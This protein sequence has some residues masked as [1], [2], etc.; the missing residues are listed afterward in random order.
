MS[1]ALRLKRANLDL[2]CRQNGNG[3]A[4]LSGF[5]A[6]TSVYELGASV[7][8]RLPWAEARNQSR[9]VTAVLEVGISESKSEA[10][11]LEQRDIDGVHRE[12]DESPD[13]VGPREKSEDLPKKHKY[14]A[15]YHW[16]PD[17][18]IW[19]AYHQTARWIPRG[20]CAFSLRHEIPQRRRKKDQSDRQQQKS[21]NLH[22]HL[23][24]G[25]PDHRR[26][27]VVSREPERNEHGHGKGKQG[28]R[29]QVARE[30]HSHFGLGAPLCQSTL[31]R[32]PRQQ[33]AFDTR[34]KSRDT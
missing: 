5:H 24:P 31:Q 4:L 11:L 29:Q 3:R 26:D 30:L 16:I 10:G 8:F 34:R 2:S 22:Q 14:N 23:R 32:I 13:E 25:R 1:T 20:E 28:D 27:V 21:D 9:D 15:G 7:I 6:S 19:S 12:K 18:A 17:V 33:G